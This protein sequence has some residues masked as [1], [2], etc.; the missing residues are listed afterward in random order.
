MKRPIADSLSPDLAAGIG[1]VK[2]VRLLGVRVG[3]WLTAEEGKKLLGTENADSLRS[4]RNRALLSLL[5]GCG[6]RRAEQTTLRFED[7]QLR[8]GH[9]VIADLR[10]KGGHIRTIPVPEWV[11]EAINSWTLGAGINSGPLLRSINKAGRIWGHGFTPKV[12]WAIVK[13]NAKSCGLTSVAPHDLRRTCARL[14][15]QAANWSRFSSCPVTFQF[16][17]P[18]DTSGASSVSGMPLTI[19]SAWSRMRPPERDCGG[20]L[21]AGR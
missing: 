18:S 2:G 12:I 6:L 9:W 7:L 4:R 14:C 13:V 5:I 15:H 8:E 1:R 19:T 11:K 20:I 16:R 10:G 17:R 21:L 3:N